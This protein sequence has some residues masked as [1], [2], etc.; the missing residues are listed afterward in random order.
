MKKIHAKD[1]RE[2]RRIQESIPKELRERLT[3]ETMV[4]PTMAKVVELGLRDKNVD[5]KVKEKLRAIKESGLLHQKE[6]VVNKSVERK[7]KAYL[8]EEIDRSIRAGRLTDNRNK[9]AEDINKLS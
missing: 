3:Y 6:S 4:T 7:I 8:D 9:H 1:L 2:L 5:E